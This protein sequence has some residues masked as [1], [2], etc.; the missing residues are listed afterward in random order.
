MANEKKIKIEVLLSFGQDL[1]K[2]LLSRGVDIK[3]IYKSKTDSIQL[4]SFLLILMFSAA[5]LYI[6]S[7][8]INIF[9]GRRYLPIQ[10]SPDVNF[11][12]I[13]GL[14]NVKKDL[15]KLVREITRCKD[16]SENRKNMPKGILF[17]GPPGSGKTLAARAVATEANVPF[18]SISGSE[19][20]SKWVGNT[21]QAIRNTF[22]HGKK[23]ARK[24]G[25]CIIFI[26]EID[27]IGS[28]RSK[29]DTA[30]AREQNSIVN[31][32][33]V[34]MD[35]F[36][37]SEGIIVIAATNFDESLDPALKRAGRFDREIIFEY[38]DQAGRIELFKILT[39]GIKLNQDVRLETLASMLAGLSGADIFNIVKEAKSS[40][41]E[42]GETIEL[43]QK[44][45]TTALER[46]L[47]GIERDHQP[48]EIEKRITAIHEAGH[49]ILSLFDPNSSI[50]RISIIPRG[51]F[52][53]VTLNPPLE[54]RITSTKTEL[55]QRIK[56]L[57]AG[58]LA[59]IIELK[60][61]ST[62]DEE[63]LR[64][65]TEIAVK[66]VTQLGMS[67][68][69]NEKLCGVRYYNDYLG[70]EEPNPIVEKAIN[71]ILKKCT[72]ETRKILEE[73]KKLLLAIAS[74]L[75]EKNTIE[76]DELISLFEEYECIKTSKQNKKR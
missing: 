57:L 44:D 67:S 1:H 75:I 38:P 3:T 66:M 41:Q 46:T 60:E 64:N 69:T 6:T 5:I 30:V 10:S 45:L 32:L 63:D 65:A 33:L 23:I 8:T 18:I 56:I 20:I 49:A 54:E 58:R 31:Q 40:A 26:D 59:Q 36:E 14:R 19:L 55:E 51:R 27:A 35:G 71:E 39:K 53:G 42:R 47:L 24:N 7:K 15:E 16:T 13:G 11:S 4:L 68:D 43:T 34:A 17:T 29:D 48:N 72:K 25:V 76:H 2:Y 37:P 52:L 28:M 74:R 73:N 61:S 9:G 22:K 70:E 12:D 62:G 50:E 21:A